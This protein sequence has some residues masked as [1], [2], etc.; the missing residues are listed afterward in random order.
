M[1]R[2]VPQPLSYEDLVGLVAVLRAEIGEVRADN[3]RLRADNEQVRAENAELRR[4]LGMDSTNSS[5]PPSSDSSYGKPSAMRRR[6]GKAGKQRGEPGVTRRQVADPDERVPV[7]P[8][9]CGGCGVGL[10]EADVVGVQKRQVF[11]ASPPPPP[12]VVQFEVIARRC[13]CC[14]QV[15]EGRAP[16]WATG[17]V[18]WGP[19]VAARGVLATIGHH[20]PYGRAAAVLAR[21]AGLQVSTGFLVAARKRA[22]A[23]L[24]PFM[25][26]VR[27][28]L[29]TAGVV[30]VD[31]T[32]ARAAGGL[33]YLHVACDDS[34]TVMHTGG[35]SKGDID[36][37]GV[38]HGYTGVIVRDGYAGYAHLVDA[39]H[40]WCGAH[41]LRDLKSVHD[42][43]P[44][45]QTGAQAMAT[46][47]TMALKATRDARA[48]GVA[49]LDE[50]QV[51][52]LRAAYAG[53]VK[54]MREENTPPVTPLQQRG[55]TLADR[56]EVHRDMILRFLHDLAV[57]FTN[58]A[59]ER[60]VRPVK[61]KQ[62]SGGGWRT[63]DGLADFAI[64]WSYL[65][66][67]AKHGL[68]HLDVLVELF[69][70]GPW[71]PDGPAP[72]PT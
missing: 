53:A 18:Q 48:A 17:R 72:A 3:E 19:S 33:A 32:P 41:L 43:D 40:A 51:A 2:D 4:R 54:T 65:S 45:A 28:L 44:D 60:E 56:F 47:L 11:E 67:A 52:F 46:A 55:L 9:V 64:I 29:R 24:E 8:G 39:L 66:T 6:G 30:H 15:T 27:Q 10:A 57:P 22:A 13:G 42:A 37:G 5:R 70:T 69:T 71:L 62:R 61:V 49:E 7:E 50:Q 23:L 31:E 25:A 35:R 34:F 26:R 14:G 63:L 12:R 20:L 68:G 21:L 16:G 58:N 59:A 1:I 38:L 36:A